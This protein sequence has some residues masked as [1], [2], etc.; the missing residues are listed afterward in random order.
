VI[1]FAERAL[2]PYNV[3]PH[4]G[5]MHQFGQ[6]QLATTFGPRFEQF[7]QIRAAVDSEGRFL[8]HYTAEM[9]G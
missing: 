2:R 8:N 6:E 4:F 1:L 9:F 5:K 7:R 3:R